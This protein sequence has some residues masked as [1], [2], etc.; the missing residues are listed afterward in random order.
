LAPGLEQQL[1]SELV[2]LALEVLLA[3]EHGRS[4]DVEDPA[5]HDASR[6][7]LAVGIHGLEDSL[8][9]HLRAP[10]P[11]RNDVILTIASLLV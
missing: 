4:G 11:L 1:L 3:L 8:E 5:D 7:A 6:L 2:A 10:H 9:L